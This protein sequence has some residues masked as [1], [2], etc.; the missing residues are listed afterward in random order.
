[1]LKIWRFSRLR[2]RSTF[3]FLLLLLLLLFLFLSGQA[4]QGNGNSAFPLV[5]FLA[6]PL[7]FP[8]PQMQ[9]RVRLLCSHSAVSAVLSET[10]HQMS[11]QF[12]CD[13]V[14]KPVISHWLWLM[15]AS[16]RGFFFF[17]A[18]RLPKHKVREKA[19][20]R[21]YLV[22]RHRVGSWFQ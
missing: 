18:T 11:E 15:M 4:R 1:M 14:K 13:K 21:I 3:L 9:M 16:D 2:R 12:A 8:T 5:L 22:P 19:S 10:N 17:I 20:K 6:L 7:P